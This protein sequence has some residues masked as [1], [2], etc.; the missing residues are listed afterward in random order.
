MAE[1]LKGKFGTEEL[2][3]VQ[4]KYDDYKRIYVVGD[5]HGMYA[6]LKS[7][8][9]QFTVN[10]DDLL[11]FLGDYIDRGAYSADCMNYVKN[12]CA[13]PNVVALMGN[14]ELMM[15]EYIAQYGWTA[16][17]MENALKHEYD[18]WMYNGGKQ[19]VRSLHRYTK[20]GFDA[21]ELV[22]WALTRP[23]LLRLDKNR[24]F[25]HA[26]YNATKELRN[27]GIDDVVWNRSEF[28]DT[29]EGTD[30]WYVGHTPVQGLPFNNS[31]EPVPVIYKNMH[32]ID[33]G[34]YIQVGRI[35][36]M[37]IKSGTVYRS[38]DDVWI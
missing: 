18:P 5:I 13:A 19:T 23:F 6:R 38:A 36:C 15:A 26:G 11:V 32:F 30:K 34:S 4:G 12:L 35:S 14:H 7:V 1:L 17:E 24:Y 28:Y 16:L 3:C 10:D 9:S 22:R 2:P 29:Y 8:M 27:C 21:K 33:T 31:T 25:S 20:W 37:E